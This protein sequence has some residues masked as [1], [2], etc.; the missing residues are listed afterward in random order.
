MF[1]VEIEGEADLKRA[2][3]SVSNIIR[4]GA[5]VGVIKGVREGA[6]EAR[7][8]HTFQNRTEKLEKSIEGVPLGWRDGMLRF[9]G[10]IRASAKHASFVENDTKPHV[11]VVRRAR[12]LTVRVNHPGTKAQPFMGLAYFKCERVMIREVERSFVAAQ[13]ALDR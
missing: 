2:W 3:G 8:K 10:S 6:E 11:I 1:S 4:D 9:E 5:S 13:G 7:T 12:F